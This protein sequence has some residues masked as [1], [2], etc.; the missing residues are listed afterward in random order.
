[1]GTK[2]DVGTNKMVI[3]VNLEEENITLNKLKQKI[4]NMLYEK[5][6]YDK[7]DIELIKILFEKKD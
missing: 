5:E 4:I 2:V 6:F 7:K 3:M 1:M